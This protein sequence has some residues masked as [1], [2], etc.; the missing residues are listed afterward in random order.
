MNEII[1]TRE[2]LTALLANLA[3]ESGEFRGTPQG[4]AIQICDLAVEPE[5][6]RNDSDIEPFDHRRALVKNV[7]C[8]RRPVEIKITGRRDSRGPDNS[9]MLWVDR[10]DRLHIRTWKTERCY[11]FSHVVETNGLI[12]VVAE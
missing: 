10:E 6:H 11:R 2:Q 8:A 12:E 1:S 7:S 3:G 9:I 5:L 4:L